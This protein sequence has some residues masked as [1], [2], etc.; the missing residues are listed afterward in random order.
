MKLYVVIVICIR[1]DFVI[2][3]FE[4]ILFVGFK[5]I[6]IVVRED[7]YYNIILIGYS[8]II[9]LLEDLIL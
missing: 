2:N 6:C 3:F 9:S 4:K 5:C 1:L 7:V 8:L